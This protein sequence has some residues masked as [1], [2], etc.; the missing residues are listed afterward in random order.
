LFAGGAW[1]YSIGGEAGARTR[2]ATGTK[3]HASTLAVNRGYNP[4][5]ALLWKDVRMARAILGAGA[6][7]LMLPYGYPLVSGATTA[8]FARASTQSLWLSV[9]VYAVWGGYLI[10]TERNTLTSRF[11]HALPVRNSR[12]AASRLIVTLAPATAVFLINVAANLALHAAAFRQSPVEE[13]VDHFFAMNWPLLVWQDSSLMFAQPTYGMP[14]AAFGVA[15]YGAASLKKPFVGIGLGIASAGAMLVIW[16]T[17][18]EGM[19]LPFQAAALFFVAGALVSA[20]LIAFGTHR[21]REA[22]AA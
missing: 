12:I 9:V 7:V 22:G 3:R 15:W 20:A 5:R 10:S 18:I 8:G 4:A 13:P 2:S 17:F 16:L 6:I 11:L 14:L 19:L 1:T 21:M